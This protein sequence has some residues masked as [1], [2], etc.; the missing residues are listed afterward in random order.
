MFTDLTALTARLNVNEVIALP[1][2]ALVLLP[3]YRTLAN[4][5]V[6]YAIRNVGSLCPG[7]TPRAQISTRWFSPRPLLATQTTS[8]HCERA[9][10]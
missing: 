8:V 5:R 6:E 7:T 2:K 1:H 10:S 3:S 4:E 9:Y